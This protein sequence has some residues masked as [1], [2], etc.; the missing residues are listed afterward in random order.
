MP[1][2]AIILLALLVPALLI[3]CKGPADGRRGKTLKLKGSDT[4][5]PISQ[6]L[7]E[8]YMKT[9]GTQAITVN[10]GGSGVGIAALLDGTTDI[11]ISSRGLKLDEKLKFFQRKEDITT[12]VVAYDALAIIVNKANPLQQITRQQV[13]DI[14]TGKVTNWKEL[15]GSDLKIVAYARETSSG[16]Y[17]FFKEHVMAKKSYAKEALNLPATG[18]IVQSVGQTP[19]AIGYVGLA[20]LD[21]SLKVLPISYKEGIFVGPSIETAKNGTYPVARPLYYFYPQNLEAKV[22]SFV[23]YCLSPQGQRGV[24]ST[25]YIPAL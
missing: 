2:A 15:G 12:V 8:E 11:A 21:P 23:A 19:G 16:T 1:R 22:K 3:N 13:E 10:G 24:A 9:P 20:Y 18:A 17:E 14:Y 6:K 5:L 25:G 4:G 7:A